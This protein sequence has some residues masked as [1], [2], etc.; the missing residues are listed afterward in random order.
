MNFGKAKKLIAFVLVVLRYKLR[1]RGVGGAS[2]DRFDSR[3]S[4]SGGDCPGWRWPE[5]RAP[6]ALYWQST[7]AIPTRTTGGNE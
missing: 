2:F 4:F 3:Q 1:V 6:E 5:Q 7:G